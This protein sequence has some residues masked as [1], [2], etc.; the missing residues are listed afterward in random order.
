MALFVTLLALLLFILPCNANF[1][2]N[3]RWSLDASARFNDN[4]ALDVSSRIYAFGFDSHKVFTSANG[5]IGYAVGQLYF[6]KLS[7]QF[8]VPFMFDSK[9]D[10]KFI[11]REAHINYTA[12][13]S[14]LPNIRLGHFTLPFGLEESIATNGRLLDYHH[15]MNLGT[16]LDWGIGLNKVLNNMEYSVSYTLGGKDDP[17]SVNGSKVISGRIGSLSHADFIVG[18][19]FYHA[20]LDNI[21]RKR[22]AIDWQ[23]YWTTWG[24]LGEL[25]IADQQDNKS[26]S[27]PMNTSAWQQEKYSLI[28]INKKSIDQQLKIYSQF[29]FI[30]KE[31]EQNTRR[32]MNI[33]L[34]YQLSREFEISLSSRKQFNQPVSGKKQDL[35]RL[36]ARYRY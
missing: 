15:G 13:S 24:L 16:K 32:L 21:K 6:T 10:N 25:A 31:F 30:D 19:S 7:N 11:V 5:D 35:F 12:S 22:L 17:K 18:L 3:F 26:T 1:T 4:A 27:N 23:Y 36:Q 20:E 9:D 33:G 34:S 29:I 2:D 8:P 28:E 14:W